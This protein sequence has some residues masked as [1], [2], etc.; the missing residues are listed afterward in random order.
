MNSIHFLFRNRLFWKISASFL[1]ILLL[2]GIGYLC[3]TNYISARYI[4]EINQQ[5]Y[6]NITSHMVKETHPIKNG[7]ADT[8]ATHDIIHSIMVINPSVELYLLDTKGK[9]IDFIVP[10]KTVKI[11][12]V[13]LAP[14]RAFIQAEGSAYILG[15]DPRNPEE[16]NVFSAAPVYEQGRLA[17]YAYAILSGS[18]QAKLMKHEGKSIMLTLGTGYFFTALLL[19]LLLGVLSTWLITKD[20]RE[21]TY[22]V[23]RFKEGDYQVRIGQKQGGE[24]AVLSNTFNEMADAIAVHTEQTKSVERLRRELIANVSHDLR[25]P[26][27][28]MQGYIET[29]IIKKEAIAAAENDKYLQI[30]LNSSRNLSQLV[31]KLFEYT[32][33]EANQVKPVKEPFFINELLG[34]ILVQFEILAAKKSIRLQF[35]PGKNAVLVFADVSLVESVLQN[36]LENAIK[37]TEENG[38]ITVSIVN[39]GN[40]VEVRVA[41]NGIG[42]RRE[43]QP[44]IFE[45]YRRLEQVS[46]GTMNKGA[47]LG[48]AIVKKILEIHQSSIQVESEPGKGSSFSFQLPAYHPVY[49]LLS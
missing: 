29:L 27:S 45:R 26:L 3:I 32:K 35:T 6:G 12:S 19:C 8:S 33:L 7:K 11:G 17:G 31:A 38:A 20:L 41:D 16:K 44:Y 46:S 42:I 14:V 39:A 21:I 28:I 43:D 24:M 49:P 10:G 1:F 47:G 40:T 48:L 36:L 13:D 5:L 34:D 22:A 30:I 23:R 4:K 9:I 37:Y 2:L 25:T 15:D 18:Q